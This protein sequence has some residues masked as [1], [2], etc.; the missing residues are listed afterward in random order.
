LEETADPY[1]T[2]TNGK[3]HDRAIVTGKLFD[4]LGLSA[5][6][7]IVGP[8]GSDVDTVINTTGLAEIIPAKNIEEIALF[9]E[10]AISA[11]TPAAKNPQAY[12]W[13]NLIKQLD[14]VLLKAIESRK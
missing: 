7:L 14:S 13:P 2:I 10:K 5:P 1:E 3:L 4:A 12:A 11:Q 6:T 8:K 9:F